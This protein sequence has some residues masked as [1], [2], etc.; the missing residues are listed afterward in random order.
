V[1]AGEATRRRC[2]SG[3]RPKADSIWRAWREGGTGLAAWCSDG[4][5]TSR[6]RRGGGDKASTSRG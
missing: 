3:R 6:A 1:Q 4:Y 2:A 5:K